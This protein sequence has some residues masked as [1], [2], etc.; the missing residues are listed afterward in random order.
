L[1]NLWGLGAFDNRHLQQHGQS[2]IQAKSF[3]SRDRLLFRAMR[4]R[5]AFAF[6]SADLISISTTL[7]D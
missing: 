6:L 1:R 4:Q 7:V 2:K 5:K 3:M